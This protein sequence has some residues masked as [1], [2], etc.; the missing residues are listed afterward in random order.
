MTQ[1][2]AAIQT[3]LSVSIVMPVKDET[4]GLGQ[5]IEYVVSLESDEIQEVIIVVG[6]ITVPETRKAAEHFQERLP[7]L[8]R[9]VAQ[10]LPGLG[11]ALRSGFASVRGTHAVTLFGDLESD[12]ATIPSMVEMARLHSGAIIVAS[13]WIPG[14]GFENYERLKYVLNWGGQA[15]LN[16]LFGRKCSDYTFG[17]RLYPKT[18]LDKYASQWEQTH[19][20]F[21]LESI[22]KPILDSTPVR[23]VPTIWRARSEGKSIATLGSYV[24]YF[25][26]AL[27][28]FFRH[29]ST[30]RAH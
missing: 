2:E 12:P 14:G 3:K 16:L 15:F 19:H 30:S 29:R 13:R 21:V 7:G 22:V 18:I 8:V 20:P 26:L 1:S 28:L 11:G 9:I 17:F 5:A 10:D 23:E 24:K 4:E 6:A 27:E 25:S